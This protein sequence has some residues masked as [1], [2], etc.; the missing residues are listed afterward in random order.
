MMFLMLII[1]SIVATNSNKILAQEKQL[2]MIKE[3][4]NESMAQVYNKIISQK[5]EEQKEES[6]EYGW[7]IKE[8]SNK[9]LVIEETEGS[10]KGNQFIAIQVP[11]TKE[12]YKKTGIEL[13][14]ITKENLESIEN[15]L[16][17]YTKEYRDDRLNKDIW[18]NG[19]GLTEDEYNSIKEKVLKEIYTNGQFW[20]SRYEAGSLEPRKSKDQKITVPYFKKGLYPYNYVTQKQAQELA[21][22]IQFE[23]GIQSENSEYKASLMFGFQYDLILK[24]MDVW[25]KED[26][27]LSE[28]IKDSQDPRNSELGN[29]RDSEFEVKEGKYSENTVFNL[30][31][32]VEWKDIKDGYKKEKD[33]SVL[34][35]TGGVEPTQN[36]YLCD[37]FG[38][39][40]EWTLEKGSDVN[41]VRR[42]G[43]YSFF[44]GVWSFRSNFDQSDWSSGFRVM[45]YPVEI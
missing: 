38:S 29:F 37:F 32:N 14:N 9:G 2:D 33:K 20:V 42:G 18:Y 13:K 31:G 28:L 17:E 44:S 8:D 34:F 1:V 30:T 21:N 16:I 36:T 35:T 10:G 43:D 4:Y 23:N 45:L 25:E 19:C 26:N 5:D 11:K 22:G 6:S 41:Q 3:S 27:N 7:I 40:N 24:Y 39:L 15:D 12:V